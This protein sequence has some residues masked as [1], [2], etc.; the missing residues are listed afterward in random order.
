MI[1][2]LQFSLPDRSGLSSPFV[3]L[4]H[5]ALVTNDMAKTVAFYRDI[6]GSEV[7]MAHRS[8]HGNAHHYFITVAPNVV[9][10][11]FEYPE[12]QSPDWTSMF[13]GED[14]PL[15]NRLL[16]HICLWVKDEQAQDALHQR[17]NEAG[18]PVNK[19]KTNNA[20]FFPDPNNVVLEVQ[21]ANP[22]RRFPIHND[23]DPVY[24]VP[25]NRRTE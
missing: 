4:H 10:A 18:V 1:S 3:A 11:F 9:F 21:I 5:V 19:G 20:I 16:E 2:T 6:L 8:I 7:A 14:V 24:P 22:D 23:P 12:A 17:L 15:Q 25:P 13:M